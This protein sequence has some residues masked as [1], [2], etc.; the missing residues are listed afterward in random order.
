M[1]TR[2]TDRSPR[3]MYFRRRGEAVY[4][5]LQLEGGRVRGGKLDVV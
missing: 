5:M 2:N 3:P 4:P 1:K